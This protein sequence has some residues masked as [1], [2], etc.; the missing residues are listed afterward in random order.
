MTSA[1]PAPAAAPWL[2]RPLGLP[3]RPRT[4]AVLAAGGAISAIWVAYAN[5]ALLLRQALAFNWWLALPAVGLTLASVA[6]RFVRWHYL[7]RRYGV[8]LPTR[9]SAGIFV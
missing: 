7:L 3:L 6:L 2:R 8:V 5:A 1:P 4:F 9:R